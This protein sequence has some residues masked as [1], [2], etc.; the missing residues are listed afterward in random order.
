MIEDL[1]IAYP[2]FNV[3]SPL[4]HTPY[5]QSLLDS[6]QMEDH[7]TSFVK[8]P[9]KDFIMPSGRDEGFNNELIDYRQG[10]V[11][12]FYKRDREKMNTLNQ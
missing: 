6:G 3:L 7:W 2:Y 1:N 12:Y 9:T 10:Y 11:D 5:Y 8:A 4:D